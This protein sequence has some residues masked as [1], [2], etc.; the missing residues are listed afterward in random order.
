MCFF[1]QWNIMRS[2]FG[3]WEYVIFHLVIQ[4]PQWILL[5]QPFKSWGAILGH[6]QLKF[7]LPSICRIRQTIV[8]PAPTERHAS[9]RHILDSRFCLFTGSLLYFYH[10]IC[11]VE[12]TA[13]IEEHLLR[14]TQN[15]WGLT[16]EEMPDAEI[17][18]IVRFKYEVCSIWLL[19]KLRHRMS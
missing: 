13:K 1:P 10:S 6:V 15:C 8:E 5:W 11:T 19:L 18:N 17:K 9:E 3:L 4:C 2:S 12:I 14:C 7:S 16:H